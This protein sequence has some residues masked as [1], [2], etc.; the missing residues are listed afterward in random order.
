MPTPPRAVPGVPEPGASLTSISRKSISLFH[1]G[2]REGLWS[3]SYFP[4]S[5]PPS[6]GLC[7][8]T[9]IPDTLLH[10]LA[11]RGLPIMGPWA[12]AVS[13]HSSVSFAKSLITHPSTFH[14]PNSVDISHLPLFLFQFSLS[15]WFRACKFFYCA[16]CI[17]SG[18]R[19]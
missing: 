13:L 15:L 6:L 18:S 10:S 9:P 16:Q 14:L 4:Y 7:A 17:L 19:N 5:P 11:S 12:S 2:A 1:W 3:V 8:D